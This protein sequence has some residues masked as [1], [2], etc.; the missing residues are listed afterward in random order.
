ME[1]NL[2]RKRNGFC[3]GKHK[4]IEKEKH[5]SYT[6]FDPNNPSLVDKPENYTTVTYDLSE[7]DGKTLLKVTQGDFAKV[8]DGERRF[9]EVNN[10]GEGWNPI[11]IEIKK[12]AES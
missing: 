4:K 12:L 6:T 7:S 3:K 1:G 2:G 11:L 8:D 9:N 10:N 5:L